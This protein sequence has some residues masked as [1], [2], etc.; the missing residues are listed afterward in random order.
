MP[1]D[2]LLDI[3]PQEQSSWASRRRRATSQYGQ[4]RA[5]LEYERSGS[6]M[7]QARRLQDLGRGFDQQRNKLPGQYARRGLKDSGVY[8]QAL[9][10]YGQ[11]RTQ[12]MG[13]AAEDYQRQM[14]GYALQERGV[15][16]GYAMTLAD[17]AEQ[18]QLR[19]QQAAQAAFLRLLGLT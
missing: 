2:P 7:D 12:T 10:D 16:E 4:Q 6:S 17:L 9:Q 11:N 8:A 14:G 19:K 15:E 13:R 3:S 5:Q 1:Y 18:E